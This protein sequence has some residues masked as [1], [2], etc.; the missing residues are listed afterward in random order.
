LGLLLAGLH[1]EVFLCCVEDLV[2]L[3]FEGVDV[4]VFDEVEMKQTLRGVDYEVSV[5][6]VVDQDLAFVA[7]GLVCGLG[8]VVDDTDTGFVY[9]CCI[10]SGLTIW[11]YQLGLEQ[12]VL[13]LLRFQY[14]AVEV[15][16]RR[17]IVVELFDVGIGWKLHCDFYGVLLVYR[18]DHHTSLFIGGDR[19][20][21]GD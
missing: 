16:D 3:V 19:D 14:V 4:F 20:D 9:R 10:G 6:F 8:G 5:R 13:Y 12:S 17:Y 18:V 1:F 7:V 21:K 2:G 11:D 15:S